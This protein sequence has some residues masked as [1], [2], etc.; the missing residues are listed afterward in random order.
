MSK[1]ENKQTNS[2]HMGFVCVCVCLVVWQ[3]AKGVGVSR[4]EG[5]WMLV[6]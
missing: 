4:S 6:I 3:G 2:L 5:E 1:T